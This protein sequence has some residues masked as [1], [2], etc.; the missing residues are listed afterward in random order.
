M[1]ARNSLLAFAISCA[2]LSFAAPAKAEW[3]ALTICTVQ[4]KNGLEAVSTGFGTGDSQ[5]SAKSMS[6]TDARK[7][8]NPS[9]PWRCSAPRVFNRGCGYIAGACNDATKRCAWAIGATQDEA[10]RKLASQGYSGG[11]TEGGC[12]G[13]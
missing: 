4:G 8:I 11:E 6:L 5:D 2:F 3:G 13:Q 12:V 1:R 9:S 10:L 7:D